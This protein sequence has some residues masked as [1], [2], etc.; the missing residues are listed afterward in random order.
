MCLFCVCVFLFKS[1]LVYAGRET[2][3]AVPHDIN[4]EVQ[5]QAHKHEFH[6]H[7]YCA[8]LSNIIRGVKL[9]MHKKHR[10]CI[11]S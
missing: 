11:G 3:G 2:G 10:I 7:S 5:S 4:L 9:Q 1:H 8:S 6:V